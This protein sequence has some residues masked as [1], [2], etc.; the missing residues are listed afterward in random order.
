MEILDKLKRIVGVGQPQIAIRG[1]D[2]PARGGGTLA[3]TVVLTGGEYD[4]RV[5]D[6]HLRLHE[7][8]LVYPTPGRPEHQF[9]AR[10]AELKIA[11]GDR[12]LRPGEVVELPFSL[13]LPDG[14]RASD[15]SV[16]YVLVADTEVPGLNPKAE[17]EVTVA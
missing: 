7:E 1:V 14:L 6:V 10:V 5:E 16:A 12:V 9:W 17:L 2:G 13:A 4:A 15:T 3:G 11:M 8:R